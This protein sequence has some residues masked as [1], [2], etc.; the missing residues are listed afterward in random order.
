MIE[1]DKK[2]RKTRRKKAETK[3]VKKDTLGPSKSSQLGIGKPKQDH[4]KA[5]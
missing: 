2:T 3:P 4:L 5:L 1:K